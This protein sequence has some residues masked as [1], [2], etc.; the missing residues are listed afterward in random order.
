MVLSGCAAYLRRYL[1][2]HCDDANAYAPGVLDLNAL[3]LAAFY[4]TPELDIARAKHGISEAA[5]QS[6]GRRFLGM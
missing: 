5:I 2:V 1:G 6:A 3:M 4:F